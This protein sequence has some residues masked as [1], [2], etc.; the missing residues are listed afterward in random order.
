[1]AVNILP[2]SEALLRP[3]SASTKSGKEVAQ[4]YGQRSSDADGYG[5][6]RGS[7]GTCQP[8]KAGHPVIVV[9][10]S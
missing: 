1:M 9:S 10:S 5:D 6:A 4:K 3:S 8:T 7:H 2:F